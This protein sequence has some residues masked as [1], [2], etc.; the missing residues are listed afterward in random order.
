MADLGRLLRVDHTTEK[1]G[2][3]GTLDVWNLGYSSVLVS[4][5]SGSVGP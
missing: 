3:S 4:D 5:I 1:R 2:T